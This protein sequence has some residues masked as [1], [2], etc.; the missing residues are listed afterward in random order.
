MKTAVRRPLRAGRKLK[1]RGAADR[2]MKYVTLVLLWA[3]CISL[4]LPVIWMI[5]SS[6]KG[7]YDYLTNMF[8]LPKEW[9]FDNY[10][11]VFEELEVKIAV[12]QQGVVVYNM[13]EMLLY[14]LLYSVIVAFM[15]VFVPSLT[16]Y[17]VSRYRFRGRNAIYIIGLF[18]MMIPIVGAMPSQMQIYKLFGIYNNFI[19]FALV[20]AGPFG[21]NFFLLYGAWK[22]IPWT[23]AEAAQI[24]GAG[25]FTI[26]WRIM[27]PMMLPTFA[28]LFV[29]GFIGAWNDYQTPYIWLPSTP[30]IASGLF[31]FQNNAGSMGFSMPVVLAGFVVVAIP[32]S[33]L[34]L[35]FQKVITSQLT[36]GGLKE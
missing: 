36:L 13:F 19:P 29:L 28:A 22:S 6:F 34:F 8:A 5:Y 21:F 12:W 3:L 14:S 18:V 11:T 26:M 15:G 4:C 16:A 1:S 23:Y 31:T 32:S 9:I 2:V 10:I 27:Y 33:V 17:A 24:D 30:N 7:G 35:V 25:H 20:S